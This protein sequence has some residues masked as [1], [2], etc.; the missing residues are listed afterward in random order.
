MAAIER[1]EGGSDTVVRG[2][3]ARALTVSRG[4]QWICDNCQHIHAH[5]GPTCE[6]C[7][8]FDTMTWREAPASEVSM[9]GGVEM[10]PFIVGRLEE[11]AKP[12]A[13]APIEDAELVEES[14]KTDEPGPET[15]KSA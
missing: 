11:K 5:W 10:L 4:P 15:A 12:G 3:L 8:G 2:W 13:D 9:P 6:N 7:G 1:G 14:G